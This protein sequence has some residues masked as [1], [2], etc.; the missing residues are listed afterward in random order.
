VK[1]LKTIFK[2]VWFL[3]KTLWFC[4]LSFI[5]FSVTRDLIEE[6]I[7][8]RKEKESQETTEDA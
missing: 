5:V 4:V 3:A 7:E 8:S 6:W 1:I 2:P